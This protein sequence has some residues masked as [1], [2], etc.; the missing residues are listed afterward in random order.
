MMIYFWLIV[1]I[2]RKYMF[3]FSPFRRYNGVRAQIPNGTQESGIT[4]KAKREQLSIE[5]LKVS[6]RHFVIDPESK[7]EEW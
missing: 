5:L 6:T 2:V 7:E 4:L 3:V 1:L